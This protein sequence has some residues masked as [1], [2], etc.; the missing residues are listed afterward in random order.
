MQDDVYQAMFEIEDRHWWYAAKQL[1]VLNLLR[2]YAPPRT[3]GAKPKIADLGC[4]CGA[5]LN[6]MGSEFDAIGVDG[7][8]RAIEFCNKRGV[9]A[10]LGQLLTGMTLP[11][12]QFDGVL[13]L[14]V[15]EHIEQDRASVEEAAGLLRP[16]GVM[17]CT[18]P[19]YQWLWSYWDTLHHH[20]RRYNKSQFGALFDQP[21]LKIELLSYANMALFPLAMAVRM[22]QRVIRPNNEKGDMKIPMAP[23]NW[24]FHTV[25]VN[26][27]HVLGRIPLPFGLS[28]VAV[29]R[30][31]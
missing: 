12:G 31:V 18:S 10:E 4:G 15:L 17:I 16:G 28:V 24:L 20:F 3:N 11:P 8:P 13:L 19:A 7:S 6:R 2:R 1:I 29:A 27:R 14:D 25:Y 26:E 21:N 9:R 30:K 23:L 22:A 5:M